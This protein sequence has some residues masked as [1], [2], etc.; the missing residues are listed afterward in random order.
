MK[1][2]QRLALIVS[3]TL[4][5]PAGGIVTVW[6]GAPDH[7]SDKV[8]LVNGAVITRAE[9]DRELRR[10]KKVY[11]MGRPIS[12][13]RLP[14]VEKKALENL[15]DRELLYQQSQKKG[16]KVDPSSLNHEIQALKKRF[17][18]EETFQS[19]LSKMDLTEGALKKEFRRAMAV[20]QLIENEV[21]SKVDVSDKL[22]RQYY[23]QHPDMFKQPER[24]RA[25]HILVKVA[26]EAGKAEKAEARKKI[27]MIRDKLKKGEDF[28][29]L[30][31]TYSQCPSSAKGGDLGY[32][33]HGQ[34]VTPFDEAAFSLKPGT[35][36][37]V[38][39]TRFGYHLIKVVDKQPASKMAYDEIKDRLE[40]QLKQQEVHKM[41]GKYVD[42]LKAEAKVERFL[43]K[44]P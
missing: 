10:A 31:K 39:E 3:L 16:I 11:G 26:P 38:V 1:I 44:A 2:V 40:D 20:Q 27:K 19:S 23:D 29:A 28:A 7:G 21:V 33:A 25:S 37:D 43:P 9:Y 4:F 36:S 6:A 24:V 22:V 5:F 15:I 42:G 14:E 41:M 30:A 35:V 8:A 32:F 13:D 12:A 34:M 17:P 18:D